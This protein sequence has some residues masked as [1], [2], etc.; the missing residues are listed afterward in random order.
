M[1][2]FNGESKEEKKARKA[3]ELMEKYGLTGFDPEYQ[4]AVWEINNNLAGNA[5]IEAGT[6]LSINGSP[7]DTAKMSYLHALV[8]Q[9]WIIIREL[10]AI[11]KS[12]EK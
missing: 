11:R 4:K 1:G 2:I 3:Q 8:N 9:N 12:L 6:A 7:A 5:L 10:D